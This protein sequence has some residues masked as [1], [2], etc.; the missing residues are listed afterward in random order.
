MKKKGAVSLTLKVVIGL[1]VSIIILIVLFMLWG[2]IWAILLP[3][4][5]EEVFQE[6]IVKIENL[7]NLEEDKKDQTL[8]FVT[9]KHFLVGFN[10][11]EDKVKL[12]K[13]F[14]GRKLHPWF[15]WVPFSK[16]IVI[17]APSKCEFKGEAICICK[18]DV[19][20][21]ENACKEYHCRVIDGFSSI[22]YYKDE[23]KKAKLFIEPE[24]RKLLELSRKENKLIIRSLS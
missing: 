21:E 17:N 1:V 9:K 23:D 13:E 22:E 7:K 10:E 16:E 5:D 4:S 14:F 2:K 24:K 20:V 6:L 18:C 19:P 8:F 11:G 15:E 3:Q 12:G